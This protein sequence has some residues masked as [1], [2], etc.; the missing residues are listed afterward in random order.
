MPLRFSY[1]ETVDFFCESV[2]DRHLHII[3][4]IITAERAFGHIEEKFL[5][6]SNFGGKQRDILENKLT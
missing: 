4:V 1:G 3:K 2:D 6:V 5:V